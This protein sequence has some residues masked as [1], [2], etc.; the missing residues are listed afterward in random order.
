MDRRYAVLLGLG[1]ELV[2]LVVAF[3]YVG[4][5]VDKRMGWN[6]FGVAGGAVLA[7]II[8]LVHI[9]VAMKAIE[10]EDPENK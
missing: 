8:W 10:S 7:L 4:A 6:G 9:T 1:F 3:L 5:F 2:V